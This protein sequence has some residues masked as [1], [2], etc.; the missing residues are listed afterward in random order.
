MAG[1]VVASPSP[2][3]RNYPGNMT[4][5][6]AMAAFVAAW[7]GLIFGYDVGISGGVTSMSSF[8][9]KFFPSVYKKEALDNST[10]QYCKFDSMILTLFTS[11]LYLAAL[12]ASFFAS[13]VTRRFGRKRSMTIGGLVFLAGAIL[14]A[15]AVNISMLIIGRILL[16]IGVGFANQSVPLYLSEMAPYKYRGG[17]SVCFQLMITIGVFFANLLNYFTSSIKGGWGWRVS[18]GGAAIPAAI[19]AIGSYF[20]PDTPNSLIERNMKE[21]ALVKLRKIRGTDN[22]ELEFQDIIA[23]S[24]ESKKV[25]NPWKTIMERKYRPQLVMAIA[26]PLFQQFTGINVVMFYAPVLFRTLGFGDNA[27]LMSSLI[28]GVVAFFS[29]L[30]SV[31]TT[32]RFG[33]RPLFILGGT[34]MVVFQVIVGVLI[35]ETFGSK[36]VAHHMSSATSFGVVACICLFVMAFGYS[37]G[38]FAWLVPSEIYSLE[39]RS[40]GQS[41][42][43]SVNM[44]FTFFIGQFFLKML[45]GMEYGLFFFFAAWEFMMTVFIYFFLPET[46]G[47]PIEEMYRVWKRH[48]FWAKFVTEESKVADEDSKEIQ[49]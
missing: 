5:Y 18:L 10:D 32:D 44:L 15:S 28:T 47:I 45:C 7:G 24:D 31:F 26:I 37:W 9:Q 11:S 1:G 12:V 29:T 2:I 13:S 23:A 30:M 41:I 46:K 38:P 25:N 21:E 48:W 14:N 36:G 17:L 34:Q 6:V 20:L 3:G 35:K 22:V 4:V 27:S 42:T 49:L 39:I 33:R 8:L 19:I 43:V 40:A 16:G